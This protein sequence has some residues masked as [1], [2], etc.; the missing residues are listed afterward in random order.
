MRYSVFISIIGRVTDIVNSGRNME[1][2][3]AV[4]K[5]KMPDVLSD[6]FLVCTTAP[7]C[8]SKKGL[9]KTLLININ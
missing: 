5:Q 8:K 1:Q 2:E 9:F 6:T 7:S 3:N 4:K